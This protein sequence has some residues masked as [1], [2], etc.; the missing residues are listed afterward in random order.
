MDAPS[1]ST[2]NSSAQQSPSVQMVPQPAPAQGNNGPSTDAFLQD[3]TL[4][5][6]AAKRAQMAIMIRDFEECGLYTVQIHKAI[7]KADNV[8]MRLERWMP[9]T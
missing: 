3:F 5:A 9:L 6:E 1:S 4:I 2:S 8:F 7:W